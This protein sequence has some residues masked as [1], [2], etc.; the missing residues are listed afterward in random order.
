MRSALESEVE[1]WAWD[2]PVGAC[3]QLS[4]SIGLSMQSARSLLPLVMLRGG[5]A[6]SYAMISHPVVCVIFMRLC[7]QLS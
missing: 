6:G 7:D 1:P 3:S 4:P 5:G 2:G